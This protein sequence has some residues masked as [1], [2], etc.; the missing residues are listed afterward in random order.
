M[1]TACPY[2]SLWFIRTFLRNSRPYYGERMELS[3][4]AAMYYFY[5][6]FDKV[7]FLNLYKT[8]CNRCV[9]WA[10]RRLLNTDNIWYPWRVRN[11]CCETVVCWTYA[12]YRSEVFWTLNSFP[13]NLHILRLRYTFTEREICN[14]FSIVVVTVNHKRLNN[15]HPLHV[16]Y[17]DIKQLEEFFW[18]IY[19]FY[20]YIYI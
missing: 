11:I 15:A 7:V 5:R 3:F 14:Y 18:H 9:P 4:R 1:S 10:N 2:Y 12:T 17:Y 13:Q 16:K 20:T 8:S 19:T 6:N